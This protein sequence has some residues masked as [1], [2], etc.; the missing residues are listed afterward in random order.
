VW[1]LALAAI[2]LIVFG[3]GLAIVAS[4]IGLFG[5]SNSSTGLKEKETAGSNSNNS[6]NTSN[7]NESSVNKSSDTTNTSLPT[8]SPTPA[9]TPEAT[10]VPTLNIVGTWTGTYTKDPGTLIISSQNGDTVSGTLNSGGY[11]IAVSGSVNPTTR[12]VV[13]RETSVL[14][15]MTAQYANWTLGVNSGTVSSDGNK[16]SGKGKAKGQA[17]YSWSFS[18]K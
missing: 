18:R 2:F 12:A 14:K 15:K 5:G 9:S 17:G 7:D 10:P 1:L 13:L 4:R 6:N 3:A 8:S 16:M 11:L